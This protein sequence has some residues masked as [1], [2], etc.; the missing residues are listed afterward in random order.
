[1][2]LVY[3]LALNNTDT[4]QKLSQITGTFYDA[5]GQVI[6]QPDHVSDYWPIEVVPAQ[7]QVPFELTVSGVQAAAS[8][9]LSAQSQFSDQTPSQN[10]EFNNQSQSTRQNLD[11]VAAAVKND[12]PDLN[13]YL[14]IIVVLFDSSNN[15]INF[16]DPYQPDDLDQVSGSQSLAFESC[17][18]PLGQSVARYEIQGWGR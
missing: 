3:G 1:M 6:A 15:V 17:A 18:D 9:S 4:T 7:G 12:G 8:Y 13:S 2:L 14:K 5:Q 10:F 16:S 11:C